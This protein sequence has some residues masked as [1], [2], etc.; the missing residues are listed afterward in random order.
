MWAER[1]AAWYRIDWYRI[2]WYRID[3]YRI[4]Q[5]FGDARKHPGNILE[6]LWGIREPVRA[7]ASQT[8]KYW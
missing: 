7:S 3:W 2:D 5:Y 1:F 8:G 4:E 6:Y